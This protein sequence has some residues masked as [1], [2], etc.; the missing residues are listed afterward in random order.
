MVNKYDSKFNVEGKIKS[1]VISDKFPRNKLCVYTIGPKTSR[2]D[3]PKFN[4]LVDPF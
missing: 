2:K 3:R 1:M 4:I